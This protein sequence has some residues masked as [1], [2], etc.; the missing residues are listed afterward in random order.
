MPNLAL[1]LVARAEVDE[2]LDKALVTIAPAPES[3]LTP[4]QAES[5]G[6]LVQSYVNLARA[7]L[8]R[9]AMAAKGTT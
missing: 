4:Q 8:E 2:Y 9:F 6:N 5:T 1:M 3:E 7:S